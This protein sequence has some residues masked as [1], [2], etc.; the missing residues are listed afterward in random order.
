M[1]M[2]GEKS[3]PGRGLLLAGLA[4]MTLII[5]AGMK[6][7]VNDDSS[8]VQQQPAASQ[9]QLFKDEEGQAP[10]PPGL[11]P[12]RSESS[13]GGGL[14]MFSK[15]NAGY[16]GED[17]STPVA[18][19]PADSAPEVKRSTAAAVRKTAA[20]QQ[21]KGTVIPRMQAPKPFGSA[22]QTEV[23]PHSPGQGMPDI[24]NMLK[25]AQQQQQSG[26]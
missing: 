20:K 15:T 3:G 2:N 8:A 22:A 11:A 25:Q 4:V 24:S 1:V 21:P 26:N 18:G 13:S 23:T 10:P 14:D 7:F 12:S 9:Q 16:Y 19:A 6:Y 5:I 17:A